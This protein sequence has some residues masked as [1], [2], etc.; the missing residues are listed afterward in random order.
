MVFAWIVV[1][2]FYEYSTRSTIAV[3]GVRILYVAAVPS[4][5]LIILLW[6]KVWKLLK[7]KKTGAQTKNKTSTTAKTKHGVEKQNIKQTFQLNFYHF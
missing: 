2:L 4:Y 6:D 1:S 7:N 5:Q 3:F